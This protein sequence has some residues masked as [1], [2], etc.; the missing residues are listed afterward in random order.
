MRACGNDEVGEEL[1]RVNFEGTLWKRYILAT[2]TR[3]LSLEVM[4]RSIYNKRDVSD[5]EI[6]R[7]QL[8]LKYRKER[9]QNAVFESIHRD[10]VMLVFA[11]RL[12][13]LTR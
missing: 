9:L 5:M 8:R 10:V 12:E 3:L 2:L 11:R 4:V 6:G 7:C 1:S 13:E